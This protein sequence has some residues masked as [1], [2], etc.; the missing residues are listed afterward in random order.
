LRKVWAVLDGPVGKQLAPFLGEIVGRLRACR[1]LD[2]AEETAA[3]LCAM[4]AAIIDRR[5]FPDRK[6]MQLK[7]RSLTKPGSLLK[8]Q[9]LDPHLGGLGRRGCPHQRRLV[10]HPDR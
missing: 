7:G 9:I 3:K 2:I 4:S 1:E 10:P 6:K 8:S 5:L